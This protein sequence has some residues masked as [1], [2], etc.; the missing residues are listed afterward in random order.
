[1]KSLKYFLFLLILIQYASY[2]QWFY[3]KGPEVTSTLYDIHIFPDNSVVAAGD[4]YSI[5]STDQGSNW[6][7]TCIP[8]YLINCSF[9]L[10]NGI[11]YAGDHYGYMLKSTNRGSNWTVL[12][13]LD[14]FLIYSVFFVTSST[15]WAGTT[16]EKIYKTTN[17]GANW[18]LQLSNGSHG[19]TSIH[20]INLNEGWA[21]GGAWNNHI[22]HTTNGGNNWILQNENISISD[23][24]PSLKC[25]YF[26]DS[27]TGY[28]GGNQGLTMYTTNGGQNWYT[29]FINGIS[30]FKIQFV[31]NLKGWGSCYNNVYA[32]TNGGINWTKQ[33]NGTD[34]GS[35][36]LNFKDKMTGWSS[37]YNGKTFYTSNGGVN[38][39]L[40]S[41]ANDNGNYKCIFFSDLNNGWVAGDEGAI[42]KSSDGGDSW[43]P[44]PKISSDNVNSIYFNDSLNGWSTRTA[45]VFKT[46]NGGFDWD[47]MLIA[48]GSDFYDI[49]FI[50]QQT[51]F[52]AGNST[53]PLD[54]G[55]VYKTS[56]AGTNWL[57]VFNGGD[58]T[59]LLDFCFPNSETGYACGYNYN[60]FKTTN[61]GDNWF[62]V[63]SMSTINK[64]FRKMYFINPYVGWIAGNN[65]VILMTYDGGYSFVNRSINITANINSIF[66]S[67][68]TIGHACSSDGTVYMTTDGGATWNI[69]LT[70]CSS[71]F[72]SIYFINSDVGW[73]AGSLHSILK[74]TNGGGP[75]G[76]GTAQNNNPAV[77]SLSQNYPNPFNPKTNINYQLPV[78][79][80]VKLSI[81]DIT[82][83]EIAILVNQ[84][85]NAGSYNVEWNASDFASG[86]YFYKLETERFTQS[87]RMVL[88]K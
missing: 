80:N 27:L 87:K 20:F 51:G 2:S 12:T 32:T 8:G 83:R 78:N 13:R 65:G 39:I 30:F 81:F 79:S 77:F 44:L 84:K 66:F 9:F 25:L 67:T 58:S 50:N 53:S 34:Y 28:A 52:A 35:L 76:S 73:I 14:S 54:S 46:T 41:G 1:M 22:F 6:T 31:N 72:N 85:Q 4:N 38:W 63:S 57:K 82:G 48:P 33:T 11:G 47:T 70:G 21:L 3:K 59:G 7:S 43:T 17:G 68:S 36:G 88:I 45:F 86:V 60:L 49:G 15:G 74:T 62:P 18:F 26:V 56:N 69:V 16:T 61:S 23:S 10:D 5:L 40:K 29:R 75:V 24:P 64:V 71:E 19:I 37:G 42:Y 55:F